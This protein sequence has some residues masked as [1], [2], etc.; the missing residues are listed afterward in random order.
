MNKQSTIHHF[1]ALP[2]IQIC[3]SFLLLTVV[4]TSCN[5]SQDKNA[6]KA[7]S[8]AHALAGNPTTAL[9][10]VVF[11]LLDMSAKDFHDHQPPVPVGFRN[12]QFKNL[13]DADAKNHYMIC[14]EF[15]SKDM[16]SNDTWTPF[17]TIKTSDYEQWIGSHAVEFCRDAKEVAYKTHDLSSALKLR[18]ESMPAIH[19]NGK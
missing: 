13:V 10:S 5:S 7:T 3:L 16:K 1:F 17:A 8:D 4:L 18:F 2:Y 14:G 19:A 6:A 15:L 11:Y 12:V 9:D